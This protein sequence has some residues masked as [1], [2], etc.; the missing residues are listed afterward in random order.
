MIYKNEIQSSFKA[1]DVCVRDVLL[2]M[3]EHPELSDESLLFKISFV[4][5]ELMNNSVEHGNNFDINKRITCE[6]FYEAPVL[7][8]EISDEGNGFVKNDGYY[9]ALD[10]DKRERRRGLKLIE[11]LNFIIEMEK[12]TIRL[13]LDIS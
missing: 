13:N 2:L 6:I 10:N 1:V 3:E 8:I 12:S 9:K 7:K 11:D 4:L 5:R